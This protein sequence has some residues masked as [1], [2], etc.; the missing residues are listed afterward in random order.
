MGLAYWAGRYQPLPGEPGRSARP[1]CGPAELLAK[2]DPVPPPRR[3]R[4]FFFDAVR[5]LDDD[6]GFV[7]AIESFE[8]DPAASLSQVLHEL[9]RAAAELYLA[10]PHARIAYVHC[11]TAPSALRL[12]APYLDEE[13]AVRAVG[14]AVQAALALHVV[15]AGRD[16]AGPDA[17]VERLACDEAEIRYRAACSLEEHAVK[18]AEAC[19]REHAIEPAPVFLLAAA[20][21]AIHLDTGAGR[22]AC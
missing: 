10:N 8:F 17:A 18:F 9:C 2:S 12:L 14:Y 1:G 13:T 4:G 7:R 6:P 21:A 20:D 5:V 3:A 15:S 22:G 19:L 11:V 16:A